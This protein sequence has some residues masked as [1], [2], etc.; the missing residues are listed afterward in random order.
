LVKF[1][2]KDFFDRCHYQ[3][4]IKKLCQSFL[5]QRKLW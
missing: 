5:W 2:I 3:S 4:F 1:L